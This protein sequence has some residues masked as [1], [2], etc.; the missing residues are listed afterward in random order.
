M[1]YRYD[2]A[3]WQRERLGESYDTLADRCGLSKSTVW[4]FV[5]GEANPTASSINRIFRAL[6]LKPKYALD[7]D[8]ERH[9][10][11]RAVVSK[12]AGR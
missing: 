3:Q 11:R 2:L 8:I 4:E 12:A 7:F 1:E 10:F 5:E 6:G 9:Q